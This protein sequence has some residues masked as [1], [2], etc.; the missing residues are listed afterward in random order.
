M[1]DDLDLQYVEPPRRAQV[2]LD[3]IG[4]R[5]RDWQRTNRRPAALTAR[6][7]LVVVEAEI[8][9]VCTTL[10]SVLSGR[11]LTEDD[12]ERLALA[13]DRIF[14]IKAEVIG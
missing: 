14:R 5:Q 7:A 3:D 9:L 13:Y 11:K 12:M 4:R 2:V 8:L 10:A 1:I 6:Q